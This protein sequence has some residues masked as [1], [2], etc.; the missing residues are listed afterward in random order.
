MWS[1]SINLLVILGIIMKTRII[2]YFYFRIEHFVMF[3]LGRCSFD[4]DAHE[5]VCMWYLT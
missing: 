5:L 2:L 1:R 3:E 4:H